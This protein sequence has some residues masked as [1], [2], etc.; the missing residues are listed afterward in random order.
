MRRHSNRQSPFAHP[1]HPAPPARRKERTDVPC[2]RPRSCDRGLAT[3]RSREGEVRSRERAGPAPCEAPIRRSAPRRAHGVSGAGATPRR[4]RPAIDPKCH[5]PSGPIRCGSAG[6]ELTPRGVTR[7]LRT[8]PS[9]VRLDN[10]LRVARATPPLGT[11]VDQSRSRPDAVSISSGSGGG[12]CLDREHVS[13][14]N[15]LR[16]PQRPHSASA[17]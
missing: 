13:L 16:Y 9:N 7:E 17:M 3:E 4:V 5:L 12:V 14:E 8:P 15:I 2:P 6:E 11:F 1:A 10:R